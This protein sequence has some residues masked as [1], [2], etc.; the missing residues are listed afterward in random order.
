M[1]GIFQWFKDSAKMKRW[2]M[3]ILVGIVFVCYGMANL[4]VKDEAITFVHAAKNNN[5]FCGRFYMC[6]IGSYIFK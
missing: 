3:L 5:L 1:K 4:I 6:S 2:V